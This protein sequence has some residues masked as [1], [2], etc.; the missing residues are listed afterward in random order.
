MA[1]TNRRQHA[2]PTRHPLRGFGRGIGRLTLPVLLM[3]G[4]PAA[5]EDDD[6]A[7]GET[8]SGSGGS[9]QGGSGTGPGNGGSNGSTGSNDGSTGSS[10]DPDGG[11]STQDG[12]GQSGPM[13]DSGS[14]GASTDGSTPN[15]GSSSDGGNGSTACA[16][17]SIPSL[18]TAPIAPD[19]NFDNPVYVTQAPGDDASLYVV[20]QPGRIRVV[21]DGQVRGTPFLDMRS[22]V[23]FPP[24]YT[25]RG[26][27]GL[28]FHPDYESNGRFFVYYTEAGSFR[29]VLAE[30]QRSSSDPLQANPTEQRRLISVED[31]EDNHNGGM[32][33]FGPDGHLYVGMGDGGGAC[34]DHGADG[35]GQNRET[36]FGAIHR[37]DPDASAPHAADGNPFVGGSGLDTMWAYGLR[38]PWRFS[39]DRKTGDLYIGDVGQNQFE[40]LDVQP[41]ASNGGENYGWR[42]F[43]GTEPSSVSNCSPPGLV[44]DHAEPILTYPIRGDSGPVQGGC[45]IIG[46]YVYR[47]SAIP[48]LQGVYLYGDFCSNDVAALR[49]CNGQVMGNQNVQSLSGQGSG[50]T[51]FGQDLDGELYIVWRDSGRVDKI[52][53]GN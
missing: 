21:R 11:G 42:D 18:D 2:H 44:D 31:T 32:I 24:G 37:L 53:P 16:S 9:T 50:L 28:A 51:S 49:Y 1:R 14:P 17:P 10:A 30:Y 22:N 7:T 15:D 47:G 12:G 38:N 5:C 36:Y 34:D 39:F 46:G 20:E 25:E 33:T 19:G 23:A 43:E 52:V 29:N 40:E 48:G 41:A 26:L 8:D 35:N 3:L 27:L 4:P 13:T 6:P 45:S